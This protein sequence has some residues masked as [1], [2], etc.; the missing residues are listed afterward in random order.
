M[1]LI[2][3]TIIHMFRSKRKPALGMMDVGR[4]TFRVVLTD[5]DILG[6][7]NNG[8]YF[9]IMDLGRIDLMIRAG[10]W[11][12][13]RAHGLYPVMASETISFRKSLNHWQKF[14]LE[15]R[16]AGV[17]EKAVYVEQRFVV[18]GEIYAKAITRARFIK[19]TGGTV[20]VAELAEVVGADVSHL[21]PPAWVQNWAT[22][23]ALPNTREAAPSS[24]ADKREA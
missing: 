23:V 13:L 21:T 5:I 9:S 6:H 15:T 17:D 11:A 4:V 2:F 20:S 18:D 24:W 10:M 14:V 22:D 7:M 1:N 12:K 3:R 19:S 16:M 8:V